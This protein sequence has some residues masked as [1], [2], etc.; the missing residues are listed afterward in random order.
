MPRVRRDSSVA[1][2]TKVVSTLGDSDRGGACSGSCISLDRGAKFS[3]G[4]GSE[5]WVSTV[6][7]KIMTDEGGAC[8]GS[9]I[10]LGDVV[11]LLGAGSEDWIFSTTDK[12]ELIS[13][14]V[15]PDRGGGAG[16]EAWIFLAR[17]VVSLLGAGGGGWVFSAADKTKVVSFL[18]DLDRG[19]AGLEARIS[20]G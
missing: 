13:L 17:G 6:A 1:D 20:L 8:L 10:S 15:N 5:D 9:C 4:A 3:L 11:V 2:R 12:T 14:S 7:D 18:V 19:G 16:L